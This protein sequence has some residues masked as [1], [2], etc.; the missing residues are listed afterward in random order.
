M[1]DVVQFLN[2]A[3]RFL[4]PSELVPEVCSGRGSGLALV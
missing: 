4:A 2:K 1:L 3:G